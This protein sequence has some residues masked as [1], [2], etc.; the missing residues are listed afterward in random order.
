MKPGT[1]HRWLLLV[2]FLWQVAL[3]PLVN[4][5]DTRSEDDALVGSLLNLAYQFSPD[6]QVSLNTM[7]NQSGNDMAADLRACAGS[8]PTTH[9]RSR[10]RRS[11]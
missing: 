4:F 3:A 5:T 10:W 8:R 11:R 2:P 9:G 7:F 6:H 1:W